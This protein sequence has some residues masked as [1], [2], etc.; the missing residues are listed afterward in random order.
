M[1]DFRYHIVS[2]VSI[3][4]ALA[5]GIVLGAGP[6]KGEI[7]STLQ[8]EVAG[9]RQDKT[10]L[11][12]QLA[13]AKTG[14]EARDSYLEA[15]SGRV[16]GGTLT[17]R[18]VALVVLPGAEAAVGEAVATGLRTAGARLASTTTVGEEWVS[19]DRKTADARDAAVAQVTKDAGVEVP[20]GS[21]EPRD[22]LLA[23]LLARTA[24]AGDSGPDDATA[25]TGLETLADAGLLSLDAPEFA[26]AD[27][28][29]VVSGSVVDGDQATRTTVA[30]RWV[31]L[32]RALDT[33]S[34]GVVVADDLTT[35]R[36]GTAVLTVLRDTS[37]AT[38]EVSSV[39][40]AG[41]PL[42]V[43]SVVFA[44]LQQD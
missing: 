26:R 23:T 8:N 14:V 42:G 35:S 9:L 16:L 12:S 7:G 36:D 3:F 39:D 10:D 11:N 31:G 30:E 18:R 25:R 37:A 28:V 34:R 22:I 19:T 13:T 44:L 5:V 29:V 27:L 6:L 24:P 4:L 15:V 38:K 21:A 43:G 17:D 2:I 40:D 33:R 1:I 32:S 20:N 41:S